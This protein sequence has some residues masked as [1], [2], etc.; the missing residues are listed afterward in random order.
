MRGLLR[1]GWLIPTMIL[2]GSCASLPTDFPRNPSQVVTDTD[3]TALGRSVAPLV[4][5]HPGTSGFY[6]LNDG[7]DALAARLLMAAQAEHGI[8]AQYYLLHDDI[9]GR[10]FVHQLL[11]AAD[12]GVRV[13]LLLDDIDTGGYEAGMVGLDAHPNVQL[14]LFNP[15][16]NRRFR[17]LNLLSETRRLNH[18]MHNKSMTVDNQI[19][20]VGGRNIGAEYFG[21]RPDLDFGDLDLL[22]VGPV[23]EEVSAAFD[24]Y[25]NSRLA[26]PVAVLNPGSDG[27][28]ALQGLREAL[29]D[30]P[31][32]ARQTPYGEALERRVLDVI[33][34]SGEPLHWARAQ[35]VADPPEKAEGDLDQ[36]DPDR[37]SARLGPLLRD[38]HRE[39]VI[40][41]PYFVPQER[42]VALFSEL[43]E[44]G[45]RVVILT[46]SLASNDVPLVHSGYAPYR[47]PLLEAG[48]ELWELRPDVPVKRRYTGLPDDS[49]SS[50]HA[51][52]FVVDRQHLYVGSLN[53]DPRSVDI[54]TEMGIV[55]EAPILA[56]ERVAGFLNALPEAAYRLRLD[57]RGEL[58]WLAQEG[59]EEVIHRQEPGTSFWLRFSTGLL[60]ILPIEDQL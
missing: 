32:Q 49:R 3:D 18:R 28:A 58:E 34:G 48:V 26:I 57:D 45:V 43:R 27:A 16:V 37:L 4:A 25:W 44:R 59:S 14:R 53:L 7:L 55:M 29:A 17:T 50:L 56:E 24:L 11:A 22:A 40:I 21:A 54:N 46:N 8:D 2:L 10:L 60:G 31:D 39:L 42:G 12:R 36:D 23:V 15:F 1:W 30:T 19:T 35:V 33:G 20:V 9:T 41:S 38:A 5:Q 52:T 6:L 51:K 47:K 13:R